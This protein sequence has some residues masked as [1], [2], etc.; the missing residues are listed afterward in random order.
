MFFL[1]SPKIT[2]MEREKAKSQHLQKILEQK[3]STRPK[4]P[5]NDH[6]TKVQHETER[7][8]KKNKTKLGTIVCCH[9]TSTPH[10]EQSGQVARRVRE[11]AS[12][13]K[14]VGSRPASGRQALPLNSSAS[15]LLFRRVQLITS[16][17]MFLPAEPRENS[18]ETSTGAL[19]CILL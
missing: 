9:M 16:K 6:L 10:R 13:P 14:V 4:S 12:T 2:M 19:I 5:R 15:P 7:N 8:L 11:S 3:L 1:I 17:K 18:L